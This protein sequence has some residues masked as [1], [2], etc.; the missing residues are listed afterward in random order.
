VKSEL[1]NAG[2]NAGAGEQG[3]VRSAVLVGSDG[4]EQHVLPGSDDVQIDDNVAR[5]ESA[6]RI[7]H[8]C[9]KPGHYLFSLSPR[10]P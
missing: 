3:F 1:V 9:R 7:E 2:L 10:H 5:G 4:L 6:R 8:M